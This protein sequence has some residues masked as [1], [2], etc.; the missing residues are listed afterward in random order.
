MGKPGKAY[1]Y[2]WAMQSIACYERIHH[3][4]WSSS[5]AFREEI[6]SLEFGKCPTWSSDSLHY[7]PYKV[8]WSNYETRYWC[9]K[10]WKP[11]LVTTATRL[12]KWNVHVISIQVN[13]NEQISAPPLFSTVLCTGCNVKFQPLIWHPCVCMHVHNYR[14]TTNVYTVLGVTYEVIWMRPTWITPCLP[15]M[16]GFRVIGWPWIV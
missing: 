9:S 16:A 7:N 8:D 12:T 3:N 2:G 4:Y 13:C 14:M 11:T 1:V 15:D 5:P 6:G 10:C